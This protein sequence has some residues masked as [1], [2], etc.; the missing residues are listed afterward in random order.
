[1]AYETTALSSGG[2]KWY[3]GA[4]AAVSWCGISTAIVPNPVLY[5]SDRLAELFLQYPALQGV[6]R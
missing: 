2:A 1:M 3:R 5:R 6:N 4:A